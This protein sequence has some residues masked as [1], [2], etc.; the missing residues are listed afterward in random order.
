M[1]H[2][3]VFN[4]DYF[5]LFNKFFFSGFSIHQGLQ[6]LV[7]LLMFDFTIVYNKLFNLIFLLLF[8]IQV[9]GSHSFVCVYFV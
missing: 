7:Y 9:N 8:F 1:E 4:D 5:P 2:S 6:N 3:D